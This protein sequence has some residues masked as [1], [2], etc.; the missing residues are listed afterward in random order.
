MALWWEEGE[1]QQ[2]MRAYIRWVGCSSGAA[3]PQEE[4]SDVAAIWANLDKGTQMRLVYESFPRFEDQLAKACKPIQR[5][6]L[7]TIVRAPG[8]TREREEALADIQVPD[9]WPAREFLSEQRRD[10]HA[11]VVED[12]WTLAHDLLRTLKVERLSRAESR[13]APDG[14]VRIPERV[15]NGLVNVLWQVMKGRRGDAEAL[16][17]GAMMGM[18]VQ[19]DP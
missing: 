19:V 4:F 15:R 12:T 16:I 2:R 6:A 5:E 9:C 13:K 18:N 3:D 8:G 1:G 7:G 10:G 17:D 11:S 14:V